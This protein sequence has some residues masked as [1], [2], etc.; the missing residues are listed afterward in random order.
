MRRDEDGENSCS[1]RVSSR[2]D[3]HASDMDRRRGFSLHHP[4]PDTHTHT[5]THSDDDTAQPITPVA[6]IS[7][8]LMSSSQDA[9]MLS[10]ASCRTIT[11]RLVL[12]PW[13]A[14]CLPLTTDG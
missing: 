11:S 1:F 2:N 3:L 13:R 8:L 4:D 6:S 9:P 10:T 12:D 7:M 14:R 5:P